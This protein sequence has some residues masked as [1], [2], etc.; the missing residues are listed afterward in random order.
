MKRLISYLEFD[1]GS[2][3]S[4]SGFGYTPVV[5]MVIISGSYYDPTV[6]IIFIKGLYYEKMVKKYFYR[7]LYSNSS[8]NALGE[9][10]FFS[11]DINIYVIFFVH[12]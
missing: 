8:K 3:I 10:D 9:N 7:Q 1:G 2:S 11:T 5:K 12:K 6:K 4:P